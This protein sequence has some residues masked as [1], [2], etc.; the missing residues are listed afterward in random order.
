MNSIPKSNNFNCFFSSS[1]QYPLICAIPNGGDVISEIG[2]ETN[3]ILI[4]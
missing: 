4:N 2:K 1:D 3:D